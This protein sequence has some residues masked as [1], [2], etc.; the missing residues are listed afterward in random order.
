MGPAPEG[1]VY[2]KP[3]EEDFTDYWRHESQTSS[4]VY[5]ASK[6]RWWRDKGRDFVQRSG[7]GVSNDRVSEP[8]SREPEENLRDR[9]RD[10]KFKGSG[11]R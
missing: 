7:R 5:F 1:G 3:R 2:H 10:L 9:R 4:T 8:R 6:T 11:R